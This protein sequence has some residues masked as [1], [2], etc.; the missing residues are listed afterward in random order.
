MTGQW[1]KGKDAEELLK[2][3]NEEEVY[4]DFED[5]E[6]GEVVKGANE[7]D[8]SKDEDEDQ[9]RMVNLDG[10]REAELAKRKERMERK[11]K[12]KKMFDSEYDGGEGDKASFYEDLKKEVDD[13]SNLNR[14]EFDGMDD[15]LRVQYEGYRSGMYVRM[16]LENVP[17]E[18]VEHFTASSPL[19]IG[20]L[21]RGEDQ[22]GFVHIRVKKHRWYPRILK[23]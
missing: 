22:V 23:N 4:G 18:M 14:S 1:S 9:P 17:C 13:Q 6:T 15:S 3:D 5:L 12:L 11:L 20:G 8:I 16:E 10:D 19:L 21:L 2:L 7:D